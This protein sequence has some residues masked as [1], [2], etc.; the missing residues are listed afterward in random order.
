MRLRANLLV[1]AI[2]ITLGLSACAP[3][4]D[5]PT[6]TAQSLQAR[7]LEIT[8]S[9]AEGDFAGAL[10]RLDQLQ[11][12]VEDALAREKITAARHDSIIASID[13]VRVDLETALALQQDENGNDK[14]SDKDKDKDNGKG[15]DKKDNE[16]D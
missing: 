16:D 1:A 9:S 15:N 10:E 14:D 11:F 6:A 4:S 13:L 7:V 5:Y 12:G 8:Q 2:A 3:V